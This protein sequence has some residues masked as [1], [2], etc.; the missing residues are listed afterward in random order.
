MFSLG[1]LLYMMLTG[2]ALFVGKNLKRIIKQN[3]QCNYRRQLARI[4]PKISQQTYILLKKLLD[5]DPKK[6]T[7]APEA[8]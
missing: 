3:K 4:K 2:E 8:L 5:K 7:S 1:V 6:R